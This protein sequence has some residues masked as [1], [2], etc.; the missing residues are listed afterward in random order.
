MKVTVITNYWLNSQGG[1]VREYTK[2]FVNALK[3]KG[4]DVSVIFREGRDSNNYKMPK[5]KV[6]FIWKTYKVLKEIEP[7][8][9]LTQGGWY[10]HLPAVLCKMS[11]SNTKIFA[12]FHTHSDKR[13]PFYK[14]IA[15]NI[16]LNRFD[17]VGFVSRALE[18]NIKEV[19]GL[20]IK[21]ETFILYAGA[22]IKQQ[23]K[24]EIEEF[25][26]TFNILKDKIVLLGQALTAFKS[27]AEGAK[28]LISA[29]KILAERGYPIVLI[30]TREGKYSS[31]LK[32]FAKKINM[33]SNVIFTGDVKNPFVP[34]AVCDIYTHI[35]L[36]EGGVSLSILEAMAMGRPIV[37][38]PVGGIP[39]AI[40][41]GKNGIL[42]EP[43]PEKIAEAIEKLIKDETLRR[44]LGENAKKTAEEKFTWEKTAETFIKIVSGEQK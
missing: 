38:T 16:I 18:K 44:K 28:L 17:K 43:E 10:A 2:N 37:T 26:E 13:L 31:M 15:Y 23:T 35:T 1:G 20:N 32:D 24:E 36:G 8:V 40:E 14:R 25:K 27:K 19:A 42:V 22:T 4:I 12:L 29:T 39:E 11:N 34:L 30:L 6:K 21:R 3:K 33:Q 41:N 9:I 7:E 5:N